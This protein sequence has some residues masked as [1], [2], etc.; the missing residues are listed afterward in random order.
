[1]NPNYLSN[2]LKKQTGYPYR[3]LVQIQKM[4]VAE[5]LLRTSEFSVSEIVHAVGYEN[6]SFFYKKFRERNGCLPNE[7]RTLAQDRNSGQ[8]NLPNTPMRRSC[9]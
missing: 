1:M 2:S 4:S 3:E 6:V 9:Q 5:Q 8:A 7:Y